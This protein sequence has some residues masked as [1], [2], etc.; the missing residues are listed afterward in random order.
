MFICTAVNVLKKFK[1]FLKLFYKYCLFVLEAARGVLVSSSSSSSMAQQPD[2]GPWP[3]LPSPSSEY[4]CNIVT[5]FL[6]ASLGDR[7]LGVLLPSTVK[8]GRTTMP[9]TFQNDPVKR[10]VTTAKRS[11][12]EQTS[13]QVRAIAN[14]VTGGWDPA[15]LKTEQLNDPD[16]G[17]IL[18]EVETGQLPELKDNANR[19]PTY[20][21]Y[22]AQWKSRCEK[23]NTR[24]QLEIRQRPISNSPDSSSSEQSKRSANQATGRIVRR[25]FEGQQTPE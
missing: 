21:S 1:R 9:M 2:I 20:K 3:P 25:S 17:P 14:V 8:A 22:W 6:K 24:A 19:I 7:S 11:R 13:K 15:T 23:R 18:Q 4:P 5:D 16:I 10:N 12:H